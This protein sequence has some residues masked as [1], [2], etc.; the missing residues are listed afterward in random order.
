MESTLTLSPARL[1]SDHRDAARLR[2]TRCLKD[3]PAG[4]LRTSFSGLRLSSRDTVGPVR[5]LPGCSS[6][7]V[8]EASEGTPRPAR[9]DIRQ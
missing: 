9:L 6:D 3:I 4:F 2:P 8:I 5:G 1:F 7:P